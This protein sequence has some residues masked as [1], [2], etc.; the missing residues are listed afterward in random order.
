MLFQRNFEHFVAG[1][2]RG[3]HDAQVLVER[4]R[5][6]I[7]RL[8]AVKALADVARSPLRL[9]LDAVLAPALPELTSFLRK[10]NRQ[11]RQ[12]SLSALQVGETVAQLW[13]G[14]VAVSETTQLQSNDSYGRLGQIGHSLIQTHI[15]PSLG[16]FVVCAIT[17]TSK[18]DDQTLRDADPTQNLIE[19]TAHMWKAVCITR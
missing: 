11:L 9:P 2:R 12:A 14:A 8:M 18:P 19:L 6:E 4:L 7:T 16:T 5:N 10:A 15:A 17:N 13:L 3:H 1:Q